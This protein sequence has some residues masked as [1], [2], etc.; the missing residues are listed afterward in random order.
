MFL[1]LGDYIDR[2][3]NPADWFIPFTEHEEQLGDAMLSPA[4]SIPTSL[5]AEI[6]RSRAASMLRLQQHLIYRVGAS[7]GILGPAVPAVRNALQEITPLLATN[8]DEIIAD[9]VATVTGVAADT[10]GSI[11]IVGWCI[12]AAAAGVQLALVIDRA[13]NTPGKM[14]GLSLPSAQQ[15]HAE[16]DID[17]ANKRLIPQ[18]ETRDWTSLFMPSMRGELHAQIR[19]NPGGN[20][21]IAWGLKDGGDV[22]RVV[23]DDRPLLKPYTWHF[24]GNG[25]S[26]ESGG[27]PFTGTDGLGAVPGT[28]QIIDVTQSAFL[29]PQNL[30]RGHET[31][32]DPRCGST[33]KTSD[34]NVG[35]WYPS[36]ANGAWSLFGYA[37]KASAATYA[38]ATQEV[39]DAWQAYCDAVYDGIEF[40]W[41]NPSWEGGYGCGAWQNALQG[42]AAAHCVGTDGLIGGF[43]AWMPTRYQTKLTAADRESWNANN[44]CARIV[45]PAMMDLREMQLELL[46]KTPMAAY[47]PSSGLG[48]MR[49][50]SVAEAFEGNRAALLKQ[51]HRSAKILLSDVVDDAYLTKLKAKG[52]GTTTGNGGIATHD[53]KP[54]RVAVPQPGKLGMAGV[55]GGG[56][57][58]GGGG[59]GA[60][61]LGGIGLFV[62]IKLLR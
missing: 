24:S 11:P 39:A 58:E 48:A 12:K 57:G 32:G 29:E 17:I 47:L 31:L 43:G 22:P 25:G 40:L 18:S 26:D 10:L 20:I 35:S 9:A 5:D 1:S 62:L 28:T 60:L 46:R 15:Y 6:V 41:R 51:H 19:K 59:G 45:K 13:M 21:V 30:H 16:T 34:V 49:D 27:L 44:L 38:I 42:L 54:P 50:A 37:T 4:A 14:I 55:L 61:I 53:Y 52:L 56:G 3:V 7:L 36:T 8:I 2:A 23:I 33:R